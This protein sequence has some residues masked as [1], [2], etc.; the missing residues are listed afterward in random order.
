MWLLRVGGCEWVG[1]GV[2]WVGEWARKKIL[3]RHRSHQPNNNNNSKQQPVQYCT[4]SQLTFFAVLLLVGGF[5]L[6]VLF[7]FFCNLACCWLLVAVMFRVVCGLWFVVWCL[8]NE[9]VRAAV[10]VRSFSHRWTVA[11]KSGRGANCSI[12]QHTTYSC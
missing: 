7:F 11:N 10:C 8:L 12:E 2:G 1:E 9:C 3:L 4:K 6:F 5:F